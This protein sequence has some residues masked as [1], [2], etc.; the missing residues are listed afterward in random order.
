[1][2]NKN[3]CPN[4]N[5]MKQE[6]WI[7][8]CAVML[9]FWPL[10][11][12]TWP[13]RFSWKPR[14]SRGPSEPRSAD[15]RRG[16]AASFHCWHRGSLLDHPHGL[17]HLAIQAPQEEKRSHQHVRGHQER[18]GGYK[19]FYLKLIV[20]YSWHA[21]FIKRLYYGKVLDSAVIPPRGP[22]RNLLVW[23]ARNRLF[24]PLWAH[25]FLN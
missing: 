20:C 14:V 1:M 12:K 3:H 5:K 4:A 23:Q 19:T 15:L 2:E 21:A 17:Q 22:H 25:L 10:L 7:L 18:C 11:T 13:F 24:Q 8:C 6:P 16:E 9:R